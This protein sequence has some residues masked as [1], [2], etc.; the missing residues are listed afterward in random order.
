MPNSDFLRV[1]F[2]GGTASGKTTLAGAF[3]DVFPLLPSSTGYIAKRTGWTFNDVQK[4]GV[5][6]VPHQWLVM[7]Q[8][9][10]SERALPSF[11]SDR[12]LCFLAYTQNQCG[13]TVVS[14]QIAT[15]MFREYQKNLRGLSALIFLM[16]PN[17]QAIQNALA[18]GGGH[19]AGWV[20]PNSIKSMYQ[21]LRITY[22]QLQIPVIEVPPMSKDD[23]YQFVKNHINQRRQQLDSIP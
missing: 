22:R 16:Q 10:E 4:G 8:Q 13:P 2:S 20:D 23:S 12:C 3:K 11:V 19:R 17:E 18:D 9:I 14:Q 7:F 21:F 15:P 1:Y 6:A 5:F